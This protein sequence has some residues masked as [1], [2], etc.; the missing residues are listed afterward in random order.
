MPES[1]AGKYLK[2]SARSQWFFSTTFRFIFT[3]PIKWLKVFLKK[4]TLF[5]NGYEFDPNYDIQYVKKYSSLLRIM[6]CRFA[7]IYIPFGII[8]PFALLGIFLVLK[9]KSR[10]N[11]SNLFLLL[12]YTGV[13]SISV[14]LFLIKAR[15][16][17]PI[18]PVFIL[19]AA[20]GIYHLFITVSKGNFSWATGS[21]FLFLCLFI[22]LCNFHFY[23]INSKDY[24]PLH[25]YLGL[26]Y[27]IRKNYNAAVK[28]YELALKEHNNQSDVYTELANTYIDMGKMFKAYMA[29]KNA[30]KINP[31]HRNALETMSFI[32]RKVKQMRPLLEKLNRNKSNKQSSTDLQR[33][34]HEEDANE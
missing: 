4:F 26:N 3:H 18:V 8:V 17:L 5:W 31:D 30:L 22:L 23:K 24:F 19:F 15:Y 28:E 21:N 1:D 25:Y 34:N 12:A 20:Y 9:N 10:F 32:H 7:G 29:C 14:I 6:M 11:R 2:S 13:F 27:V 16:R 33:L